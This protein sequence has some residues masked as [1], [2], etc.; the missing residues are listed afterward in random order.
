MHIKRFKPTLF[1]Y[2]EG[3]EEGATENIEEVTPEATEE[4]EEVETSEDAEVEEVEETTE[5]EAEDT[6]AEETKDAATEEDEEVEDPNERIK[7][8]EAELLEQIKT[9]ELKNVGLPEEFLPLI[10][11][12]NKAEI[13]AS[14]ALL[15]KLVGDTKAT[16]E[17]A[18]KKQFVRT[19]TPG[20]GTPSVTLS[21][22]EF[23]KSIMERK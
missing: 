7:R 2:P 18:V 23:Y 1:F 6:E 21:D 12:S 11:G 22:E 3:V 4:K 16:T 10:T 19:K 20:A 9:G 15:K 17:A 8:L 5:A 13:E 14:G